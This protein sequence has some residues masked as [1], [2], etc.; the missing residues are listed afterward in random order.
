MRTVSEIDKC[1]P[2]RLEKGSIMKKYV[3]S[4]AECLVKPEL[5]E[6]EF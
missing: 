5:E 4:D 2:I 3:V 6:P 1:T